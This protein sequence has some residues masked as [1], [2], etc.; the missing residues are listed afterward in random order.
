M[1]AEKQ[2]MAEEMKGYHEGSSF[3]ILADYRGLSVDQTDDLRNRLYDV[4]ARYNVVKN[5]I[6]RVAASK[7]LCE[8]GLEAGLRGS[9]CHD[10]RPW[11]CGSGG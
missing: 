10:S 4:D 7:E 9:V 1:R 6:L 2:S 5:R 8:R 11:R 3:F